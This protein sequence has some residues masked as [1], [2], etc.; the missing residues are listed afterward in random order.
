MLFMKMTPSAIEPTKSVNCFNS[1]CYDLVFPNDVVLFPNTVNVI[2]T[3][4]ATIVPSG[5]MMV[6]HHLACMEKYPWKVAGNIIYTLP[7]TS[8]I[9]VPVITDTIQCVQAN[10][11]LLHFQLQKIA[12]HVIR[13]QGILKYTVFK[14]FL[15]CKNLQYFS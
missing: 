13:H 15:K 4:L 5:Y 2:D 9:F 6:V 3:E 8:A 10:T 7:S 12:D 1:E 11:P 14:L